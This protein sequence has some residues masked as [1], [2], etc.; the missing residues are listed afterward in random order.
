MCHLSRHPGD[1]NDLAV[2]RGG[3]RSFQE[4]GTASAKTDSNAEQ[5]TGR[6]SAMWSKK[7]KSG[8]RSVW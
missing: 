2:G 7:G 1:E 5:K 3:E 4:A 6:I 8:S